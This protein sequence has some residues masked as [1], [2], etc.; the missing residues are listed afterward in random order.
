[1]DSVWARDPTEGFI[2]A[3]ISELLVEGAEVIPVNSKFPKRVLPFS[4]IF[5]AQE[6]D[7][8]KD[9]DDNCEMVFLNEG[10]LLNNIRI[11]YYQNKIYTYVANILIAVNPYKDIPQL[12][13]PQ[14]IKNYQGKSLGQMPPHVFA[15]ADKAF[16]DM[17]TLKQSQ[18]IIV[19]GESGAGKTES[20]KHLLK[21]LC[22]NWGAQA[23][24][25]EQKILDAN[26]VLEAFGNAKTTRNNNSSR[27]GKFMEVHFDK[28]FHVAGGHISHYLLEKSRICSPQGDERSYH[29]F[30]MMMAGAPEGLRQKLALT[31]PDDFNYLKSGC[32]RYFTTAAN[33]KKLTP[34]QKSADH[35]KNGPL[36]DILIDDIADFLTLDGALSRLGLSDSD[37]FD[38]Y[39]TVAAVLHLGNIEFEENPEDTRGGCRVSPSKAKSLEIASGLLGIDPTELRQALEARVMQ[40]SRGGAKGTVIMVPLKVYEANNARDALAKAIYS[41]LFDYIVNRINQSIPFQTSSYYI[42]VLDIAGF[43]FFTVNSFEQFCINYC[44]EKLQQF[45]NEV[46]LKNEQE[47]YKREGLSVPEVNFVDNQDCINLIET[48]S[49]GILQILDEESKLPKPSYSH[50]TS[51]VHKHWPNEFRI[52][53]PR[54]SKLKSH[55]SLRD[56]EGF[57]IRHF[58]GAVCYQTKQ[59]IDKN[60]DAL[61]ASLEGIVQD[62]KSKLIQTLFA[63]SN[64]QKGKLT[65]ISVGNKFKTQLL[66]LMEKLRKNGTNFIRCIKPNNKMLDNQFDGALCLMQ[67]KCLGMTSVLELMEHG[68]PS[69]APFTDLYNMYKEYLPPELKKLNPKTFCEAML[70]SLKLKDRDFK[71]G[72]TRVFFRPGKFAEFDKI[73]K[74]DPENL[75]AIIADVK[76]FLVKSRWTKAQFCALTVI[77]LKNKIIYRKRAL[78]VVQKTV[79]GYLTRKRHG[80]RI[81][82]LTKIK[83]LDGNLK[84]MEAIAGQLKKEKEATTNEIN[85]L[86]TEISGTIGRIKK[87]DKMA[88]SALDGLY[89]QLVAKVDKQ[90]DSLQKKLLEQKNAEE[91]ARL[92]KIQ[93]EMERE[94]KRKEEEERRLREEEENRKKKAEMEARRKK[95]EEERKRQEEADRRTAELLQAQQAKDELD[96]RRYQ[97]Q[98]EQERQDH[99]LALRLAQ[100]SNGQLEESPPMIRKSEA[101]KNQ[102]AALA[103]GKYDLTKWKYSE[104]RDTINTSC[105]IEL[106][107]A[108]RHEFHR[109]LKVYHAWK[110][111]NRKRTIMDENERAPRSVMESAARTP[112][113]QQKAP[114]L[115]NNSQRY[116]RIPFVRPGGDNS[117]RGWWYAHF[118]GQ[119]VARQ[120]ELHPEKAPI[121][122]VAGK[123]DMQMCELSL[124]ETGLTRKRG[125][126][127]L[128]SEFNKEWE[129]HGGAKYV[130]PADRKQ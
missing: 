41:N 119:Y 40:S 104:L 30:Y 92:K 55:R 9:Y 26:P 105:D 10:S 100:E 65:F 126:E 80:P 24:P 83:S 124:E 77:K 23:G 7:V 1:M 8:N 101:V 115:D 61:H 60:N 85:Q 91:Q 121:L 47:L 5:K 111:K 42:G 15:I 34:G 32:T 56:D 62:S 66:E 99:E 35:S 113:I 89:K 28:N 90:M 106:L 129:K 74:S 64:A 12:Y 21:Y 103:K 72:V 37:R 14:T 51:E 130:R 19:S 67:L 45:F 63:T 6:D 94:K 88:A 3:R 58:A 43:E 16:R 116:F 2:L 87:E 114:V 69:R 38:I 84:K 11:R 25:I 4:D 68:Y 107:E 39:S 123:D 95:E 53:L 122:L 33:E 79:K 73:M 52:G 71:F 17:K 31:K 108:C 128:E 57:L 86:K 27:F 44:N 97:E 81:K 70:H 29:I 59:F 102:Q 112:K 93:E 18:S 109:R 82:A 22:V 20:T 120:I 48:K 117:K 110:A 49:N 127:I 125:A 118:D 76:K 50:F 98:L 36:K 96:E 78:V 75:K 13:S 54:S 46:I